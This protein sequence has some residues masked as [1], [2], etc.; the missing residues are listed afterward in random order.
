MANLLQKFQ[1][2]KLTDEKTKVIVGKCLKKAFDEVK[3][4]AL[5]AEEILYVAWFFQVPQ[6]DE[7]F[8]DHQNHNYDITPLN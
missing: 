1:N 2:T 5:E 7:M 4:D 8:A 3:N 6:F